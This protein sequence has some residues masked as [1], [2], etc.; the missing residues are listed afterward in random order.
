MNTKPTEKNLKVA[1]PTS[2]AKLIAAYRSGAAQR[3]A[4]SKLLVLAESPP[5]GV[6]GKDGVLTVTMAI[7]A[8]PMSKLGG[9]AKVFGR[10]KIS[11]PEYKR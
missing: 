8:K 11:I 3:R 5:A 6:Q 1:M 7:D 4:K 2:D 10:S 9:V